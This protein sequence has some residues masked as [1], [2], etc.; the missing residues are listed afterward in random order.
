MAPAPFPP[1]DPVFLWVS[2]FRAFL[3]W[4]FYYTEL[5][6]GAC[7]SVVFL[8]S[9]AN[10][11]LNSLSLKGQKVFSE[12]NDLYRIYYI[13]SLW[14]NVQLSSVQSLSHVQLFLTPWTDCMPVLPFQ[15]QLPEYTQTH[16]HWV[17]DVIQPSHSLPS[18]SSSINLS[19]HQGLFKWVSYLHQV[20]KVLEFPASISVLPM[21]TQDWYPLGRTGWISLQSKG[22][23]RVFSNII[24]QK[25]QFFSTQLSLYS[26]SH[27]HT[28]PL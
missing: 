25:H 14:P 7:F 1:I 2:R 10:N 15:Y 8:G 4:F 16:V 11:E 21:D 24:V 28:W 9:W 3:G 12:E 13:K 17:G 27:I 22:L 19:Q 5:G 6:K 20:A 23:S 26:N 18:P